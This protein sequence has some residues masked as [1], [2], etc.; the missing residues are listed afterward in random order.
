MYYVK[1]QIGY[2]KLLLCSF[3]C[4]FFPFNYAFL[5]YLP[6]FRMQECYFFFQRIV[7][8]GSSL[9][10]GYARLGNDYLASSYPI[11]FMTNLPFE[12]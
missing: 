7:S 1:V 8:S 6:L 4:F 11:N 5:I 9:C 2:N 10:Q 3:I 12:I